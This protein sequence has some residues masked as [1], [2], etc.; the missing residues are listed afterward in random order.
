M[1]VIIVKAIED[2]PLSWESFIE[3]FHHSPRAVSTSPYNAASNML[4]GLGFPGGATR[5]IP[6]ANFSQFR[7][8]CGAI[9]LVT[10]SQCVGRGDVVTSHSLEPCEVCNGVGFLLPDGDTTRRGRISATDKRHK[11]RSI[12]RSPH[13]DE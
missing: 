10:C 11:I 7:I 5:T 6:N 8:E 1:F 13:S 4:F 2:D 9:D 12:L 3:G